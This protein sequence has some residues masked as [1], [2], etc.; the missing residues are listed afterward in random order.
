MQ[1]VE[2]ARDHGPEFSILTGQIAIKLW[3]DLEATIEKAL[4]FAYDDATAEQVLAKVLLEELYLLVIT[5]DN[6][7]QA[8]ATLERVQRKSGAT[9]HCMTLG[10]DDLESWVDQFIDT[11]KVLAAD[12]QCDRI[13][14]KG[15]AGWQRYAKAKG[16]KHM[17]T[18]MYQEVTEK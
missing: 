3:P 5:R 10:G 18:I 7:I 6:K 4:A 8:T 17:Y 15:R 11:W 2:M 1:V 13:S 9:L 12:L 14:I 16:F